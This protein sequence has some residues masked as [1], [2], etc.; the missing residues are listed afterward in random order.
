MTSKLETAKQKLAGAIHA[1]EDEISYLMQNDVVGV[2]K[3]NI[4]MKENAI[5]KQQVADFKSKNTEIANELAETLNQLDIYL[6]QKDA[7]NICNN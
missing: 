3:L 4:V 6:N 1:L 2:D 5:L 7:D